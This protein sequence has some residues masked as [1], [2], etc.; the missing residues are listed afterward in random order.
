MKQLLWILPILALAACS[1][2]DR[3]TSSSSRSAVPEPQSTGGSSGDR[4]SS[5]TV[6]PGSNRLP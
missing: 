5:P 6:A 4:G 3:Q 2:Y 1:Q